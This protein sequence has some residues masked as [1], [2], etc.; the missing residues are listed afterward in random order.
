MEAEKQVRAAEERI[1]AAIAGRD[2]PA[3]EAELAP[4]FAHTPLGSPD[5]DRAAFLRAIQEMPFRILEL[6]GLDLR[7][8]VLEEVVT[9]AGFQEA[10]VEMPDG[11]VVVGRSAF[12]D[13][14][15]RNGSGWSL[16]HAVS[17]ELQETPE[18]V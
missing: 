5:Q 17:V 14:F 12:V 8:R 11:T 1:F 16:R 15:T 4:D 13:T 7:A 6:R 10:R 2:I 9:L 3:L 18:A